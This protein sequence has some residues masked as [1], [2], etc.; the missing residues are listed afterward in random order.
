MSIAQ[1][2]WEDGEPV[3][4]QLAG[5]DREQ[6]QAAERLTLLLSDGR[7]VI[8]IQQRVRHGTACAV[9]RGSLFQRPCS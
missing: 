9:C 1:C 2:R 3:K 5:P 4:V 6:V 7:G 8:A